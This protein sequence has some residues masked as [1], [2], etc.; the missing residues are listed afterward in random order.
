MRLCWPLVPAASFGPSQWPE[1]KAVAP[2]S[3]KIDPASLGSVSLDSSSHEAALTVQ[4]RAPGGPFIT[5]VSTPS[6]LWQIQLLHQEP[7]SWHRAS[8][9]Q[10]PCK[11]MQSFPLL[12]LR[13][14]VCLCPNSRRVPA[15]G[16]C[17]DVSS[18]QNHEKC[19][20]VVPTPQCS[21]V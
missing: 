21:Y 8:P 17:K 19:F 12:R 15:E 11:R 2:F 16:P 4:L 1:T 5:N 10:A 13:V 9:C 20:V 14:V 18:C 7:A 3:M 6:D